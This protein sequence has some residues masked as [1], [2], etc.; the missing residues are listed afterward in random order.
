MLFLLE[1]PSS[2]DELLLNWIEAGRE[3]ASQRGK[4]RGTSITNEIP[5]FSLYNH[6]G[7]RFDQSRHATCSKPSSQPGALPEQ[8]KRVAKKPSKGA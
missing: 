3:V 1:L 4:M 5:N 7:A 8:R 2:V 6:G